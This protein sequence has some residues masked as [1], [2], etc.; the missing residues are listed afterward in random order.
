MGGLPG[1]ADAAVMEL[2]RGEMT[3]AKRPPLCQRRTEYAHY[4][5]LLDWLRTQPD[6]APNLT[7]G[8]TITHRLCQ[9]TAYERFQRREVSEP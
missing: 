2:C 1:F 6:F 4:R 7:D 3:T 8:M 5:G 9:T